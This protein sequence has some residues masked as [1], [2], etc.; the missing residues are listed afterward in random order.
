MEEHWYLVT[1]ERSTIYRVKAVSVEKAI[2]ILC[3]GELPDDAGSMKASG[4]V[5]EIDETTLNMSGLL[6]LNQEEG[7][8]EN[9]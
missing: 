2:Q 4:Q 8:K 1:I 6:D 5:Q 7:N 9:G 3:D